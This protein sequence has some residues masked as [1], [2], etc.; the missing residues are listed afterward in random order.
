MPVSPG[1]LRSYVLEDSQGVDTMGSGPFAS[2]LGVERTPEDEA[3]AVP[4]IPVF[5]ASLPGVVEDRLMLTFSSGTPTPTPMPLIP[6][7][8]PSV[9]VP[10]GASGP[11]VAPE[12]APE[13]GRIAG[14]P[15]AET[16]MGDRPEEPSP[17]GAGLIADVFP[18]DRFA[19]DEA[20]DRFLARIEDLDPRQAATMERVSATLAILAAAVALEVVR[21]QFRYRHDSEDGR[22]PRVAA[23]GGDPLPLGLPGWPGPWSASPR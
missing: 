1:L 2:R 20:I 6:P 19:L 3:F 11:L 23:A 18:F 5:S 16:P 12:A 15:E 7:P 14:V 17:Q 21:R 8:L 4:A 9:E 10:R 13:S 22:G